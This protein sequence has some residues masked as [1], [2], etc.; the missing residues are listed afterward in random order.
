MTFEKLTHRAPLMLAVVAVAA[1]A[2]SGCE[3]TK[4]VLG[5]TKQAP[6]EFAVYSR[7][8]LSLPPEYSLRPPAPG[9]E[10]PQAVNPRDRARDAVLTA[11]GSR[12]P[13]QSSRG[14][15]PADASRGE[16]AILHRTGAL[17]ADSEIRGVVDRES[18]FLA[19]EEKTITDRIIFWGVPTASGAAVDAVAESK[20]LREARALGRPLAD[21]EVPIIKRRQ[22][23]LLED[24]VK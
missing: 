2:L 7:A 22:K 24:L 4:R 14:A 9:S 16:V 5:Q 13:V 12:P 15:T 21:G 1:M 3:Q 17:N 19:E 20:R 11:G 8:P 23:G 6:D 10:R 18:A